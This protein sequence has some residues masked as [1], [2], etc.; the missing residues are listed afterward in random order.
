VLKKLGIKPK[1]GR[2]V[3]MDKADH[4]LSKSTG[5]RREAEAFRQRIL[6]KLEGG[7]ISGAIKD[8]LQDLEQFGNK[9]KAGANQ[10]LK[11]SS[12]GCEVR[13]LAGR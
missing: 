4:A 9:Y 13:D 1:E 2:P 10:A 8:S 7:D 12:R 6:D 11:S 3:Q 5:S